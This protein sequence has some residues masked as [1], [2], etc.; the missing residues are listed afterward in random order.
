MEIGVADGENAKEMV[1]VASEYFPAEE[2]EY[3]GF[4]TFGWGNDSQMEHVRQKLE[5]TGCQI[6]LFKGDSAITLPKTVKGLP[7]MDLIFIDGGHYHT[8]VKSDWE[9]S[10]SLMHEKT[11]VFFHNYD[12]SGP[13]RVVNNISREEYQVEI[14]DPPLDSRTALVKKKTRARSKREGTLGLY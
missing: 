9:N 11:A 14:I 6:K 8:T 5:E 12:F 10:K 4:D 7:M 1:K 13:K 3:Y 2:V